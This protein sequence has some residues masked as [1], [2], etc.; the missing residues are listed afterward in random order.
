MQ[1]KLE[2]G[3]NQDLIFTCSL[4]GSYFDNNTEEITIHIF[5]ATFI[6][7]CVEFQQRKVDSRVR[8]SC[9]Y[10]ANISVSG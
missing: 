1:E 3:K 7:N 4:L 10:I 9:P 6:M 5:V 8:W 2:N